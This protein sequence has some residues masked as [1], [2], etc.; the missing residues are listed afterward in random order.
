[1]LLECVEERKEMITFRS[2]LC[3]IDLSPESDAAL[4]YGIA[5]AR[6]FELSHSLDVRDSFSPSRRTRQSN[7]VCWVTL[8]PLAQEKNGMRDCLGN[9]LSF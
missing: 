5:L 3:P 6:A 8:T 7:G 1:V 2:I 9:K 4:R